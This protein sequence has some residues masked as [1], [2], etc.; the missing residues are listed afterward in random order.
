[1]RS[2][3]ERDLDLLRWCATHYV[4]PLS[5]ILKRTV[6]PNVPKGDD[7]DVDRLPA[8]VS[9]VSYVVDVAPHGEKVS[10][11]LEG[12]LDEGESALVMVPSV[13]EAEAIG[14]SLRSQL[15][16][17]VL[18]VHS[19]QPAATQTRAWEIAAGS[20]ATVL[21]GTREVALWPVAKLSNIVVVEEARRVMRSP[22]TPTLGVR[23]IAHKRAENCGVP[24]TFVGP[25]P[26]SEALSMGATVEAPKTRWWPLVEVVDRG[27]E[28]P[29][30]APLLERTR[31]AIAAV[32]GNGGSV[33]VLVPRRGDAASFR[34]MKCGAL[35]LCESCSSAADAADSCR[36]CG[37]ALGPCAD[38]GYSRFRPLGVGIGSVR[39][40][41]AR[42][43]G[44]DVGVVGEDRLVTVGTERDLIGVEGMNLSVAVDFDGVALAP[45]YLAGESA[46]RL[47]VRLAG[48]VARGRGHRCL[49][50][51]SDPDQPVVVA[52]RSG[53]ATGFLASEAALRERSGFPPY[54]QLLALEIADSAPE[55]ELDKGLRGAIGD[56]ATVL[57]PAPMPDR[58]RWL[59]Q[60]P[61]LS[62]AKVPLRGFV[63]AIRDRG[64]RVRVDVDPIDL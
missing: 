6:P 59:V 29:S 24:V 46:L 48:T 30:G 33:F 39:D 11:L 51:T 31:A 7:D 14:K 50:Q 28:P 17:H 42:I 25:M 21:V 8:S 2:F 47:L 43:I 54:G 13:S 35:R 22:S 37:S 3:T 45:N 23:E 52:L 12:T 61:D 4:A 62:S 32:A 55:D 64:G 27:D 63:R 16:D 9:S 10:E 20:G 60:A 58:A 38:C 5:T 19:D 57:G 18:T 26:S 44:G 49:I 41:L 15:G 40:D 53:E 1:M 56:D 36:R 34:C